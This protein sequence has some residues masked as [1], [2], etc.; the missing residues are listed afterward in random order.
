[1]LLK[2]CAVTVDGCG[3]RAVPSLAVKPDTVGGGSDHR[4]KLYRRPTHCRRH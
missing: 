1:V 4:L 2:I 3:Q